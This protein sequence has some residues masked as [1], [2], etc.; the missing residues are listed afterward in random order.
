MFYVQSSHKELGVIYLAISLV[1]HLI[2]DRL[3]F[4]IWY[5]NITS[6]N[7]LFKFLGTQETSSINIDGCEFF[8][9]VFNLVLVSHLH[10]DI[11]SSFFELANTLKRLKT[12]QYIFTYDHVLFQIALRHFDEPFVLESLLSTETVVRIHN[13]KL[14]NQIF[15]FG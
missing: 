11:H 4:F 8:F 1:V 9:E 3:N 7:C 14:R 15:H 10:E 5:V 12:V 6:H 13:Q 2:D